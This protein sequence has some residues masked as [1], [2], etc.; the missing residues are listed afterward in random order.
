MGVWLGALGRLTVT[1]EPDV[2]LI[3]DYVYFS[4]HTCPDLYREDEIFP[5]TWYFDSENHLASGIGKF[6]E[7]SIWYRHLKENF[8]EPRGYQ[9]IGDSEI[10]GECDLD[11][12]KLG[13]EREQEKRLFRQR[14]NELIQDTES[15]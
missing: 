5:N 1:P 12:W 9:L 7:P 2:N 13:E 4:K 15:V 8:F 6:A 14:V 10:V 3:K 11:I